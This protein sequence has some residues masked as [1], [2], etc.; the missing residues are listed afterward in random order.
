MSIKRQ[1]YAITILLFV[2]FAVCSTT[3]AQIRYKFQKVVV[4][5]AILLPPSIYYMV[6]IF[7][8][9]K[10]LS[11][12]EFP[13]AQ[14][15]A[16]S[17]LYIR[18]FSIFFCFCYFWYISFDKFRWYA[19]VLLSTQWKLHRVLSKHCLCSRIEWQCCF[20]PLFD[21]YFLF[22]LFLLHIVFCSRTWWCPFNAHVFH[23]L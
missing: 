15:Y 17:K 3:N 11:S 23:H 9:I 4:K 12:L 21:A 14:C 5:L 22:L 7:N 2:T 10:Y 1:Q 19:H 13:L 20:S 18:Y 6:L 16:S 8:A